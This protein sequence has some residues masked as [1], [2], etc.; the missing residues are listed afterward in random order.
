MIISTSFSTV[1]KALIVSY[2]VSEFQNQYLNTV[3][4]AVTTSEATINPET[5]GPGV[6]QASRE[7]TIGEERMSYSS[8]PSKQVTRVNSP[9]WE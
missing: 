6:F 2:L 7:S 4:E 8:Y 1:Y 9:K 3:E 5:I